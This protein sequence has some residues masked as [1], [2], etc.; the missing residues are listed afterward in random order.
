VRLGGS[1]PDSL[2]P[3]PRRLLAPSGAGR[4]WG[5]RWFSWRHLW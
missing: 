2:W 3:G 4:R 1:A 5:D